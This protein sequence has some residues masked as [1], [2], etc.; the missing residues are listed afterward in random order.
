MPLSPEALRAK[1][2]EEWARL[3]KSYPGIPEQPNN[4]FLVSI[5]LYTALVPDFER[6][7]A[8]QGGDLQR[9]YGE[10]RKLARSPALNGRSSPGPLSAQRR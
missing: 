2:A 8:E 7:L 10:V 6:L 9:F 1:K 5:A 4:G 3:R